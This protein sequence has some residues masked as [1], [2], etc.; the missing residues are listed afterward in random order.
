MTDYT[1]PPVTAEDLATLDNEYS[2][3]KPPGNDFDPVPDG[4]YQA[5]VH[6]VS[7]DRIK[8]YILLKWQLKIINGTCAGR[9]MFKTNFINEGQL[10][11]LKADL[12]R[13]GVN[14]ELLHDL[15]DRLKDLLDVVVEVQQKTST[16]TD[17]NG[18]PYVNTYINRMVGEPKQTGDNDE[19]LF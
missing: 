11:Y 1:D 15:P 10:G 5:R 19:V 8:E 6:K 9:V 4:T 18:E 7:L 2:D 17:K 16:K 12:S 3:S 13:C 14:L